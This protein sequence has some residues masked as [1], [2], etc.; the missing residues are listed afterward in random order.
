[1]TEENPTNEE[2][3]DFFTEEG[4]WIEEQLKAEDYED[5]PVC[6]QMVEC[7]K[8][9]H[10]DTQEMLMAADRIQE[11][12]EGEVGKE[13]AKTLMAIS[14]VWYLLHKEDMLAL[15]QAAHLPNTVMKAHPE[16]AISKMQKRKIRSGKNLR[17]AAKKRSGRKK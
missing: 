5:C 16:L 17:K 15:L 10:N 8:H 12:I 6:S 1:M 7:L 2:L 4:Q 3:E 14:K 11:E 13:E 9:L